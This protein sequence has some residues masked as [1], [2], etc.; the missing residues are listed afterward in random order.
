MT[1]TEEIGIEGGDI[2][3]QEMSALCCTGVES[4]FGATMESIHIEP[5]GLRV[6]GFMMAC[7]YDAKSQSIWGMK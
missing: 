7:Q 1:D 5:V 3:L 6:C 4:A 2:L